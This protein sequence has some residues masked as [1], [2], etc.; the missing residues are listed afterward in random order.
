MLSDWGVPEW[1]HTSS[2]IVDSFSWISNLENRSIGFVFF[3][4]RYFRENTV[5]LYASVICLTSFHVDKY[6]TG[7]QHI[8]IYLVCVFSMS[9]RL[10]FSTTA[11]CVWTIFTQQA[12]TV[13]VLMQPA[14][15]VRVKMAWRRSRWSVSIYCA[16]LD[17]VWTNLATLQ[18]SKPSLLTELT[19]E[20]RLNV[21]CVIATAFTFLP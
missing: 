11:C 17:F 18:D 13:D 20:L 7:S 8:Y 9:F 15:A 4:V 5:C 14:W 21:A 1:A 10:Q 19:V 3:A 16:G 2:W 6:A 12:N